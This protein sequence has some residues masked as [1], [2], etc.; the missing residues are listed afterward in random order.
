MRCT[1]NLIMCLLCVAEFKNENCTINKLAPFNEKMLQYNQYV[2]CCSV[3][4]EVDQQFERGIGSGFSGRQ[5]SHDD[6]AGGFAS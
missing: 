4:G 6:R 3:Q 1:L 5:W 2:T